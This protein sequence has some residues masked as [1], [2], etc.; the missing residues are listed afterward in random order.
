MSLVPFVSPCIS[1]HTVRPSVSCTNTQVWGFETLTSEQLRP[2]GEGKEG[3]GRSKGDNGGS[4]ALYRKRGRVYPETGC[5]LDNLT[6]WVYEV[7]GF[8]A[9]R[10]A[11]RGRGQGPSFALRSPLVL[12]VCLPSC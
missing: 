10:G 5:A 4:S 3:K 8:G 9:T 2:A 6:L 7:V 1:C 11:A 12:C